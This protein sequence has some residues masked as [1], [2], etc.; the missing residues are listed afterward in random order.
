MKEKKEI[1][2]V[3]GN[4]THTHTPI[5][6]QGWCQD[7]S[8]SLSTQNSSTLIFTP[9]FH[10]NNSLAEQHRRCAFFKVHPPLTQ[11]YST[12]LEFFILIPFPWHP[13]MKG[14]NGLNSTR[15]QGAGK[16]QG[17]SGRMLKGGKTAN[18]DRKRQHES[19]S[20]FLFL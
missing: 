2:V 10:R 18:K 12:C 20:Q 6:T 16:I 17:I 4:H 8:F 19:F 11:L 14:R 15:A 7:L 3:K 13:K 1:L 5:I 9:S